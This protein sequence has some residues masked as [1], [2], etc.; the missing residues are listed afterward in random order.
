[1]SEHYIKEANCGPGEK[2]GDHD[3]Y[4]LWEIAFIWVPPC[5]F[6]SKG[7]RNP[8]NFFNFTKKNTCTSRNRVNKLY[9]LKKIMELSK[10]PQNRQNILHTKTKLQKK[11]HFCNVI[12]KEVCDL[13]IY[14]AN[15]VFLDCIC[16][17]G[18]LYNENFWIFGPLN[19]CFAC[20]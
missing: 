5:L 17:L 3:W 4:A 18:A 2:L 14:I 11:G 19:F 12:L 9:W 6:N 13:T 16:G 1:M 15:I 8:S 10:M 20:L 7:F